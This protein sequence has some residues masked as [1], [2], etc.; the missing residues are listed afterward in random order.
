MALKT[1]LTIQ[2]LSKAYGNQVLFEDAH[3][4]IHE[5]QKIGLIGR[6][7]AGKSTLMRIITNEEEADRGDIIFHPG[8]SIGYLRQQDEFLPDETIIDYLTRASGKE[9]WQCGKA[10]YRFELTKDWLYLPIDSLSGGYQMR[11]K[12]AAMV[13]R[14]PNLIL[15]DEPTN[16]LDLATVIL[17]EQFIREFKGSVIVI[18]H[19]REFLKRTC[20]HTMEVEHGTITMFPRPLE[21]YLSHKEVSRE[22]MERF[23]EK[24][25]KQKEHLQSFVNRFGA[26]AAKAGQA[27][28]KLKQIARLD[29][30]E[31]KNPLPTVDINIRKIDQTKGVALRVNNMSI[32]YKDTTIAK[33]LNVEID[34]GEHVVIL[35]N[36][37]QG[38]ST[39]MKTI[40]AMILPTSGAFRWT[41]MLQIAYFG[42][43]STES[44]NPMD[45]VL[46]HLRKSAGSGV[47]HE[48][49]MRMAGNFLF[50]DD[51]LEK[52]INM[53]SG[54][55][56]ARLAL[57]AMLLTKNDVI[58][59]DE[60][61]NHLDFQTA[62]ALAFALAGSNRTV[63]FISHDRTFVSIVAERLIEIK[64]GQIREY[65]G[66]YQDYV[67]E[68]VLSASQLDRTAQKPKPRIVEA[69]EAEGN[70][71]SELKER[72][73]NLEIEIADLQKEKA[74]LLRQ[75]E[76][77]NGEFNLAR[78][79]RFKGTEDLIKQK[80]AEW[81]EVQTDIEGVK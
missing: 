62:E 67:D 30:I 60:P 41:P 37:G 31:I 7:G 45:T 6:N 15:L 55:E 61:T 44:M 52:K 34:K 80:E 76:Q 75:F 70:N 72:L 51:E 58:L 22:V 10:A 50:R 23:N 65:M 35:G 53:L 5:N 48:D 63:I 19:D 59:L 25:L 18:S 14:E 33:G 39:L 49:I 36:N 66:S 47:G 38:K 68:L 79:E 73:R 32:G 11:V 21:E 13:A 26:S 54:G 56:K 1:Y 16:Y 78:T 12:L 74:K 64:D 43:Q 69:K 40:S 17:L 24:V 77:S 20:D 27:Q 81:L 28:S 42:Q 46:L 4:T 29:T 3:I 8:V 57:A 2:G 71:K 9:E